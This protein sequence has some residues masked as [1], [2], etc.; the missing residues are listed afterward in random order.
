[1]AS[2]N[3]FKNVCLAILCYLDKSLDISRV[4]G[5]VRGN[6]Y[7]GGDGALYKCNYGFDIFAISGGGEAGV[8]VKTIF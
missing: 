6:L 5:L 8:S 2:G 1:M 4:W 3:C 7:R